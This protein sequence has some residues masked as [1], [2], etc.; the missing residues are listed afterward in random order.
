VSCF[1]ASLKFQPADHAFPWLS[2]EYVA[3]VA[4]CNSSLLIMPV[5]DSP[6]SEWLWCLSAIIACWLC[7]S[8]A[9]QMVSAMPCCNFSPLLMTVLNSLVGEWWWCFGAISAY[10]CC[11]LLAL[12]NVSDYG[13]LLQFYPLI[14]P[15]PLCYSNTPW[16]TRMYVCTFCLHL[17][18]DFSLVSI[19]GQY[20]LYVYLTNLSHFFQKAN[21]IMSL[22]AFQNVLYLSF[23]CHYGLQY[24]LP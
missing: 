13:S 4:C 6:G 22:N 7:L 5:L 11:L 14:I 17:L 20:S 18:K 23:I 19:D 9:L 21:H 10:S 12:Q 16:N 2:S 8:L 3:V 24:M 15:F 1:G